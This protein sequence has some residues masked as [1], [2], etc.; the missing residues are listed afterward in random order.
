MAFNRLSR[1]LTVSYLL[2][3]ALYSLTSSLEVQAILLK[4]HQVPI[5]YS[6][7]VFI[8]PFRWATYLAKVCSNALTNWKRCRVVGL[9][10]L[11]M[12]AIFVPFVYFIR[13]C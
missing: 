3:L 10:L 9:G 11:W 5:V 2:A 4:T 7:L 12:L 13:L 6:V 8:R 1:V